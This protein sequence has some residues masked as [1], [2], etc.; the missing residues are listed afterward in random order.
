MYSRKWVHDDGQLWRISERLWKWNLIGY[1]SSVFRKKSPKTNVL[2]P[3]HCKHKTCNR[4]KNRVSVLIKLHAAERLGKRNKVRAFISP[5]HLWHVQHEWRW[6]PSFS[7][8]ILFTLEPKSHN[9]HTTTAAKW[10]PV[11][12]G[13]MARGFAA[14]LDQGYNSLHHC[15]SLRRGTCQKTRGS[16]YAHEK[17]K[18]CI[19]CFCWHPWFICKHDSFVRSYNVTIWCFWC[20]TKPTAS[21]REP[22]QFLTSSLHRCRLHTHAASWRRRVRVNCW[23]GADSR[24]ISQHL[25][26]YLPFQKFAGPSVAQVCYE[27]L[28]S[29]THTN[30]CTHAH[31]LPPLPLS[32]RCCFPFL[33]FCLLFHSQYTGRNC[34]TE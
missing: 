2:K 7:A 26:K 8:V 16:T 31:F 1:A 27:S 15:L 24:H 20:W 9:N 28:L 33:L 3:K 34:L 10:A 19:A 17:L 32:R 11:V 13:F 22:K 12:Q 6:L 4:S 29:F 21:Q 30:A 5:Q 23:R 18:T 14:Q 25:D